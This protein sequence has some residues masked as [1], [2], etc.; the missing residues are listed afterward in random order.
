MQINNAFESGVNL[1][2]YLKIEFHG[3]Q[4]QE[5]IIGLEKK[6]DV[7]KYAKQEY[8]WFQMREIRYGLEQGV[9]V[10]QF[11][12]PEFTPRQMEVIRKGVVE[13]LD[14]SPYAK[15]YYEPEEM[16]E[17]CRRIQNEGAVLT[18]EVSQALQNTLLSERDEEDERQEK[19]AEPSAKKKDYIEKQADIIEIE[20]TDEVL[21]E[22]EETDK[23]KEDEETDDAFHMALDSCIFIAEDLM[24]VSI[25]FS[26][27]KDI[28]RKKLDKL[29]VSDIILL[30]KNRD[31]KQGI[32]RNRIK[33]MLDN[34]VYDKPVT[35]AEGKAAVNGE[36]G[37]FTYYFRK[38][39]DRKPRVL[40]DGSVDYKNMTLFESV[41]KDKLIAEYKPLLSV[42]SV[43]M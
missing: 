18:E 9:D 12:N 14:V 20:E 35:I 4:L 43:M 2:P 17:I 16:E 37:E 3:V 21:E 25:D 10:S 13:G 41:E 38:K 6:L 8:N 5:I 42:C 15:L 34:K 1:S 31:V 33:A 36:N 24:S 32:S 19:K 11:A 30:L 22:I 40:E 27:V 29:E 23:T 26:Q 39:L 28:L 7:S